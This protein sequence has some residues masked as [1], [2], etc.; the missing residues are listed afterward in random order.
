MIFRFYS[1]TLSRV[2]KAMAVGI[3]MLGLI[4]IGLGV[5]V[6][7][8]PKVFAYLVA[9]LF[10]AAGLGCAGVAARIFLTYR[11]LAK[12]IPGQDDMRSHNVQVRAPGEG[13][14]PPNRERTP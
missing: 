6:A 13:Y 5:L 10:V 4:L 9:G 14:R 7:A 8:F 1:Q 3:F 11:R 2:S 12:T